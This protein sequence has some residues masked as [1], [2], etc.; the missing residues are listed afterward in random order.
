MQVSFLVNKMNE[1]S[2]GG[3][4]G[5]TRER[6]R[7]KIA[8]LSQPEM[9]C[10]TDAL[11]MI[12]NWMKEPLRPPMIEPKFTVSGALAHLPNWHRMRLALLKSITTG[13]LID[14][15]FYAYNKLLDD[16]PVNQKPLFVSSIVIEQWLPAIMTRKSDRS[17][18]F[19]PFQ[20]T[21]KETVGIACLVDGPADDYEGWHGE[22]PFETLREETALSVSSL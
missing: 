13:T 4:E 8:S 5:A 11:V 1:E 21:I 19:V 7:N 15:Q 6:L 22:P 12:W 10:A 14:V 9:R 20:R 16:L 18:H 17:L 3:T 2:K